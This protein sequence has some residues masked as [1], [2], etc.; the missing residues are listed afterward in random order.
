M[1][2]QTVIE[3]NEWLQQL[4]ENLPDRY[5]TRME[6]L[7]LPSH[8]L[9]IKKG[10]DNPYIF[11]LVTGEMLV[12]NE[13]DNGR[14]YSYAVKKAPGFMGL[15]EL[16]A[17][18]KKS[19]STVITQCESGFIRIKKQDFATWIQSDFKAYQTVSRYFAKQMYFSIK[20]VGSIGVF[21]KKKNMVKYLV[22][23]CKQSVISTGKARLPLNREELAF[24]L[25][26]SLRTLYRVTA[27]LEKEGLCS[28][29]KGK[30]TVNFQ[31]IE[32]MEEYLENERE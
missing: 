19:T 26:M 15:L 32:L 25:G 20:D 1:T 4:F 11:I 21:S 29:E 9:I 23:H 6:Y 24:Q 5:L 27:S 18:E 7:E 13:Y 8:K 17:E 14:N 3:N 28:L 31:Q 2:I 10:I 16:L 22:L 12:M 30:I